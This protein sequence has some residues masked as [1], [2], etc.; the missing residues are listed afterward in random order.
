MHASMHKRTGDLWNEQVELQGIR[1]SLSPSL[2]GSTTRQLR[3]QPSSMFCVVPSAPFS[4]T[5]GLSSETARIETTDPYKRI[6]FTV[7]ESPCLPFC[8][9]ICTS[10]VAA[11]EKGLGKSTCMRLSN[12]EMDTSSLLSFNAAHPAPSRICDITVLQL[13]IPESIRNSRCAKLWLAFFHL[14]ISKV[15]TVTTPLRCPIDCNC[16]MNAAIS[17]HEKREQTMAAAWMGLRPAAVCKI[18][19]ANQP[20]CCQ[21]P[22]SILLAARV[23]QSIIHRH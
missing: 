14:C 8:I 9:T 11:C 3:E 10:T 13:F 20:W 2:Q 5:T 21:P 7:N 18:T 16:E 1:I 15:H 23:S 4:S 12:E 19:N 6:S 17:F 22:S